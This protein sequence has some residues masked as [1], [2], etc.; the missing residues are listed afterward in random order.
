MPPNVVYGL[1]S[2]NSN[3]MNSNNPH[4]GI[5]EADTARTLDGN[6]GN[7]T[8]N[9]G[10][11]I[12]CFEPGAASRVGGHVYEDGKSGTIRAKAGDNQ[13]AVVYEN[14]RQDAR[15][16]QCDDISPTVVAKY[17]TGGGNT[18]LVAFCLDRA[19]YNQG[20][21]AQFDISIQEEQ[22][23]TLVAKGPHAVCQPIY[24]IGNGQVDQ[25]GLHE[26]AGTLNCMHDQQAILLPEEL[27]Y[28]VRRLTPLECCRLQGFADWWVYGIETPEPTEDDIIYWSDVHE[29]HRIITKP[30]NPKTG[31]LVG[32]KT[33]N[34]IIKW[35]K[36]PQNDGAEYKMW[37]NSLAIPCAYTV[38][39]GIAD[40][41]R[42][43]R[44]ANGE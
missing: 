17:G 7:P 8:C 19:S 40:E 24:T 21:N 1:C 11:M 22:A 35:L 18:P 25:T 4:S 20:K 43:E 37:G 39:A 14:H 44:S 2:K 42:N 10:G 36:E 6:G 23:Q 29:Q 5:Y 15:I 26:K 38:L 13:M 28:I 16:T 33:R 3:A 31:E 9:Q 12:I 27:E 32:P 30:T 34:Q 41:L